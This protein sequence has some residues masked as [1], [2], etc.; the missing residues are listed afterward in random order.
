MVTFKAGAKL[1][2]EP[3]RSYS[4]IKT[5]CLATCIGTLVALRLVFR[6]LQAVWASAAMTAPKNGGF[7]LVSDFR[8]VNKQIENIAGVMPNQ[9]AEM[10]D[11][12]GGNIFWEA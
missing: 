4:L 6:N 1:V 7:R 10:T 8:A 3:R 5:A 11:L 9:K 2:K 12:W